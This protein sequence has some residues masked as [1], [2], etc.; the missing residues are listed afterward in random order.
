MKTTWAS[1]FTEN[2]K[3]MTIPFAGGFK[4]IVNFETEMCYKIGGN[5]V[6]DKFSVKGMK[7]DYFT[8]LVL[9]FAKAVKH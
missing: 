3:V 9:N 8:Q 4:I 1:E 5:D 7:L 6:I 2:G